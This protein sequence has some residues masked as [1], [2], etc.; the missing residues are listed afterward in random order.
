MRKIF[1]NNNFML[2]LIA[3]NCF[4]VLH[5]ILLITYSDSLTFSLENDIE[6]NYNI[7]I[8]VR[9]KQ[10]FFFYRSHNTIALLFLCIYLCFC[11]SKKIYL[12]AV[13]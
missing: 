7:L 5:C 9:V 13:K 11:K 2:V 3:M 8:Y 4:V 12:N 1:L 6:Y 10:V